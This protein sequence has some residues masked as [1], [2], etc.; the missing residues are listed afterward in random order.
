MEAYRMRKKGIKDYVCELK[1]SVYDHLTVFLQGRL[2]KHEDYFTCGGVAYKYARFATNAAY[3]SERVI[4]LPII[5]K[6]IND[7][8]P[9]GVRLLEVGNVLNHYSFF[10]HQ[11]VD[12]YEQGPGVLNWDIA[13]YASLFADFNLVISIS[14]LEHVGYDE[15]DKDPEK[16][17]IAL[18]KMKGA[19]KKGG[20]VVFTVP[21][22]YNKQLDR[23]LMDGTIQSSEMY[24]MRRVSCEND[25][26]EESLDLLKTTSFEYGKPYKYGS[27]ILIVVIDVV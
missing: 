25:W 26:V 7:Y 17:L 2:H 8:A 1:C 16:V 10:P 4:E 27:W 24:L 12:K 11:I 22:G 19:T 3:S 18:E 20:K 15:E 5:M 9:H 23:Y 6:Y 14:T 21:L 13:D